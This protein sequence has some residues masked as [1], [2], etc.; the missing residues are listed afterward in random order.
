M[1]LVELMKRGLLKFV[2]SQN[3]DGLHARSGIPS[4]KLAEVH[5]NANMEVCRQ[6]GRRYMRDFDT[7]M[8]NFDHRTGRKCDDPNCREDLYDSIINFG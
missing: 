7:C 4:D 6:C 5:G 3:V 2:I 1:S 8:G